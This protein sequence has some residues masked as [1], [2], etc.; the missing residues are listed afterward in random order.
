GLPEVVFFARG[1]KLE[2][3]RQAA[4]LGF[5]LFYPDSS[6]AS[7]LEYIARRQ[8]AGKTVVYV[9]D[10][11]AESVVARQADLAVEVIEPPYWERRGAPVALLAPDLLRFIRLHAH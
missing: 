6:T 11:V 8:E 10:C 2:A 4:S 9:G 5:D 7:K 3:E 1:A